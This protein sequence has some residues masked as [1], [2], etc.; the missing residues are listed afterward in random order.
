MLNNV[1]NDQNFY[2]SSDF[3]ELTKL[4]LEKLDYNQLPTDHKLL[5]LKHVKSS[6]SMQIVSNMQKDDL[7]KLRMENEKL[8]QGLPPVYNI[9]TPV[10][11]FNIN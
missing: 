5:L 6:V 2:D 3:L 8:K 7:R 11:Q 1:N 4:L 10:Y 9:P